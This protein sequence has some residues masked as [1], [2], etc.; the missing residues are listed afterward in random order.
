MEV[1]VVEKQMNKQDD[2]VKKIE[3]QEG[4]VCV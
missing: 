4:V 2:G 1:W 3:R